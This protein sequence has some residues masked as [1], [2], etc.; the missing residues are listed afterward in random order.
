MK[1]NVL[2]AAVIAAVA[3]LRV[4]TGALT[5]PGAVARSNG[6]N[7]SARDKNKPAG[8]AGSSEEA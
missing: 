5:I 3:G 1:R 8:S 4:L 6:K 7:N 2:I